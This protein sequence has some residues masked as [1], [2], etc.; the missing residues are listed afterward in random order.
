MSRIRFKGTFDH[1]NRLYPLNTYRTARGSPPKG[2][3]EGAGPISG[4]HP[5]RNCIAAIPRPWLAAGPGPGPWRAAGSGPGPWLA[6]GPGPGRWQRP[7]KNQY[8]NYKII[9]K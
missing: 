7:I 8:Y 2:R 4:P 9:N 5:E 6:A 1:L 3:V